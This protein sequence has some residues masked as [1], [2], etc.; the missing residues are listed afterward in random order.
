MRQKNTK[1]TPPILISRPSLARNQNDV[2]ETRFSNM[3]HSEKVFEHKD[4][5]QACELYRE[6]TAREEPVK[7][8]S[9]KK[10]S[11]TSDKKD[12]EIEVTDDLFVKRKK[13]LSYDEIVTSLKTPQEVKPFTLGVLD[14][15]DTFIQMVED[16]FQKNLRELPQPEK[17]REDGTDK[18]KWLY[19]KAQD[20]RETEAH[21]F[22]SSRIDW[23]SKDAR[24]ETSK[25][26]KEDYSFIQYLAPLVRKAIES[27]AVSLQDFQ[28]IWELSERY[29]RMG[30]RMITKHRFSRRKN[31]Q[32]SERGASERKKTTPPAEEIRRVYEKYL[33]NNKPWKAK[34]K[35]AIELNTSIDT[36]K[37]RLKET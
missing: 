1:Q 32:G 4:G 3:H 16:D 26:M 35:T 7:P 19:L 11:L 5:S 20:D 18:D 36:V 30:I 22:A 28:N 29:T 24:I 34:Q 33:L 6:L 14:S 8:T 10:V 27:G 9:K 25:S 13:T 15:V 12:T 31:Q 17:P 37:R 21:P 23:T 2:D